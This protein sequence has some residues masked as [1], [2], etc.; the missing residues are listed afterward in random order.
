MMVPF[1]VD[2]D[3]LFWLDHILFSWSG[4]IYSYDNLTGSRDDFRVGVC[5]NRIATDPWCHSEFP[6]RC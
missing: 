4:L 1:D 3:F 5:F 6:G 2:Q